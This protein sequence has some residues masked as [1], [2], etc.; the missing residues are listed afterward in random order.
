MFYNSK[1]SKLTEELNFTF[2]LEYYTLKFSNMNKGEL[3][4][5]TRCRQIITNTFFCQLQ[6]SVSGLKPQLVS[7]GPSVNDAQRVDMKFI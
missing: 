4:L 2:N 1:N 3:L 5:K 7:N 6:A